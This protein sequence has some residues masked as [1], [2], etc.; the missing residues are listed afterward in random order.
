MSKRLTTEQFIEKAKQVHGD[1]YDYSRV[2]YTRSNDKVRI[3][4]KIHGV[5]QQTPDKHVNAGQGCPKCGRTATTTASTHTI[6]QFIKKSHDIH[7]NKYNYSNVEYVGAHKKVKIECKKHGIFLQRPNDHLSGYGCKLCANENHKDTKEEFVTKAN[8]IHNSKY[9]YDKFI[10]IR[11]NIKGTITCPIH[12][13]FLQTPRVHLFAGT[14]KGCHSCG[15]RA[16]SN[17][18]KFIKKAQIKHGDNYDYSQVDYTIAHNKVNI[19]CKTHGSFQQVASEH[20]KGYGCSKCIG[21]ISKKETNWLNSIGVPDTPL[22]RQVTIKIN[23]NQQIRV[24]GFN[25]N[26][27]TIYEFYG[28]FWHGHPTRYNSKNVNPLNYS[29]FGELYNKTQRKRQ[30]I[31]DA[32]YN[33]VEIWE[34]DWDKINQIL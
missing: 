1:K 18:F 12:G 10:Y 14:G 22:F 28:D 26:T 17:T 7:G 31:L 19:I 5:F 23:I 32:G 20:L 33:L 16:Q 25:P 21:S 3:V 24:D 11:H 27:K 4:C 8:Q 9:N 29:T 30:A 6:E 15:E 2:T 34:S 13:D